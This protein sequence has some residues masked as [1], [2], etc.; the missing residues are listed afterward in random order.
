MPQGY[1]GSVNVGGGWGPPGLNQ[2]ML[3]ADREQAVR[4]LSR[5]ASMAGGAIAGA[6]KAGPSKAD[7]ESYYEST[8]A[9]QPDRPRATVGQRAMGAMMG[10]AEGGDEEF[11][12][13]NQEYKALQQYA[14]AAYG[15]PKDRTNPMGLDELKGV[16]RGREF[17]QLREDAARDQ[18]LKEREQAVREAQQRALDSYYQAQTSNAADRNRQQADEFKAAQNWQA[19]MGDYA[20]AYGPDAIQAAVA[21]ANRIAPGGMPTGV[22]SD[23]MQRQDASKPAF[24]PSIVDLPGGRKAFMSSP[25]SATLVPN[26]KP[27]ANADRRLQVTALDKQITALQ[28]RLLGASGDERKALGKRIEELSQQMMDIV[29]LQGGKSSAANPNDPLGLFP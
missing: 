3:L 8:A 25:N 11:K 4:G 10:A 24:Q 2:G 5:L 19:A 16:V 6:V 21:Y 20:D 14:E 18:Q 28:N 12:R 1:F 15:I 27:E 7:W 23:L 9:E 17:Q 26:P 22:A 13:R 29:G